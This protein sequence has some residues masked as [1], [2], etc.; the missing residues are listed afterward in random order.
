MFLR[1][2]TLLFV[3]LFAPMALADA[4][5]DEAP[6][7]DIVGSLDSLDIASNCQGVAIVIYP[8]ITIEPL[9]M[10]NDLLK[11]PDYSDAYPITNIMHTM[12]MTGNAL[13]VSPLMRVGRSL[14]NL[15]YDQFIAMNTK[16]TI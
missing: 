8:A 11:L 2:V 10:S 15:S 14:S 16:P 4:L 9:G 5:W 12:N 3:F 13:E 6:P 7:I 1:I